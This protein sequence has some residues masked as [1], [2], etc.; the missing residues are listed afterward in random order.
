MGQSA[1]NIYGYAVNIGVAYL[2]SKLSKP[3][4]NQDR[5]ND[6]MPTTL[7]SQGAFIPLLI[8][9]RR[10]GVVFAWAGDR[11]QTSGTSISSKG[12]RKRKKN[13]ATQTWIEAGWHLLCVGP[14]NKL[15]AIYQD[16]KIIYDTPI[17]SVTTPSGT[18]LQTLTGESFV[19]YWGEEDQ[20]V[21]T[22]L[23]ASGRVEISSRW[24]FHCYAQ[25]T[26][27]ALGAQPRWQL[28]EYDLEAYPQQPVCALGH[29]ALGTDAADPVLEEWFS[30]SSQH[31]GTQSVVLGDI[32]VDNPPAT[33]VVPTTGW[34]RIVETP[35]PVDENSA[36][37]LTWATQTSGTVFES[38]TL[39]SV[40]IT[41]GGQRVFYEED[42]PEVTAT[43]TKPCWGVFD[44]FSHTWNYKSIKGWVYLTAGSHDVRINLTITQ[45]G[46]LI[47][48]KWQ[49]W[50][51]I[52]LQRLDP[53]TIREGESPISALSQI[54][55]SE[56]PHGLGLDT[57]E[58]DLESLDDASD[59]AEEEGVLC[60]VLAQDGQEAL[61]VV[62][63]IMQDL[64]MVL[65]RS[66]T[67]GLLTFAL[68]RQV[69]SP[70]VISADMVCA[71]LPEVEMPQGERQ[72]TRLMFTFPDRDRRFRESVVTIDEDG[73]ADSLA[74]H[75]ARKV[76]LPTVTDLVTANIVAERRS[77][78]ELAGAGRFT[79]SLNRGARNLVPGDV[80]SLTGQG[81]PLLRVLEVAP[82]SLSG[83]CK[84]G[85]VPD[86]YGATATTYETEAS[87]GGTSDVVAAAE[88]LQA[89]IFEIP[90]FLLG[91]DP[92]TIAV[93]RIRAHEQVQFADLHLS[94][95][96]VTYGLVDREFS[97]Q[98]GGELLEAI[99]AADSFEMSPTAG[100]TFTLLGPDADTLQDLSSDE[101]NW[102]LGRQVAVI[103]DEIFFL[104][105]P[106]AVSG[107]TYR[108][109]GLLRARFDTQRAAHA[110]GAKVFI[111][112]LNELLSFND[113]LVAPG[114]DVYVKSQPW[115]S[116][117]LSLGSITALTKTL[118]GKGLVPMSPA[119]LEVTAPF[120]GVPAF[121]TG[122]DVTFRWA[123]RTGA[124]P[125]TGAG[126]QPAGSAVGT[127]PAD[128]EFEVQVYDGADVLVATYGAADGVTESGWTYDNADLQADLGSEEDFRVEVRN[129]N[130]GWR[131]DPI[132]LE[133]EFLAA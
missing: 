43:P 34:Y 72:A 110:I 21:N 105:K 37:Y 52:Q 107:T 104:R 65:Y 112:D 74:H 9:R 91:G 78:E 35:G 47:D 19:W 8:G 92:P 6:F 58:F 29:M 1:L 86:Y 16:G 25:W 68:L 45:D 51:R 71:P 62:A 116:L 15:H 119:A 83:A 57:A 33:F 117:P 77:Q 114:Q 59:A 122:E 85:C 75:R 53:A 129:V 131:S 100:P 13:A 64:G 36:G 2:A 23:G 96:D 70:R 108:L 67:T 84:V 125:G 20:D 50:C 7:A 126:M 56:A 31:T 95:D 133:V 101:A 32:H 81:F 10:I 98:T 124:L 39:D 24:P 115:T 79:L 87:G 130:G 118:V 11:G 30:I 93:P 82:E 46:T 80:V 48:N 102:R 54:L 111:F 109:D 5:A 18:T 63:A 88:D 40:E 55:F 61:A 120:L 97:L 132:E 99:T 49:V 69:A 113:P 44:A 3:K 27:K 128:G 38:G 121:R 94:G 103:D 4:G 89:E 73:A 127:A 26:Q 12:S 41:I 60:S 28:M 76:E 90:A 42:V 106:T 14:A 66:P 123:H 22:F 17:D